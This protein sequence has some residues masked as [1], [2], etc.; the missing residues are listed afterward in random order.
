MENKQEWYLDHDEIIHRCLSSKF[1]DFGS[2]TW[3][4]NDNPKKKQ[5][6]TCLECN[7]KV[8]DYIILQW[9]LLYGK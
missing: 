5:L 8:P 6:W 1:G 9:K 2:L 7:K 3:N 4:L